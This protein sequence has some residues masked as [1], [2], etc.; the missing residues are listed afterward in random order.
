[1]PLNLIRVL[2][3]IL[4]IW[5]AVFFVADLVRAQNSLPLCQS[6]QDRSHCYAK[7]PYANGRGYF[8]GEWKGG[9]QNGFGLTRNPGGVY[10]GEF[11][12]NKFQGLG[13][14]TFANGLRFVGEFHENFSNGEGILYNPDGI[15]ISS[16]FWLQGELVRSYAIDTNRFPYAGVTREMIQ[17]ETRAQSSDRRTEDEPQVRLDR[18]IQPGASSQTNLQPT[19]HTMENLPPG[20]VCTP[21]RDNARK[22]S[23]TIPCPIEF[24]PSLKGSELTYVPSPLV[25]KTGRPLTSSV[26]SQPVSRLGDNT[27]QSNQCVPKT[28]VLDVPPPASLEDKYKAE[29]AQVR[30]RRDSCNRLIAESQLYTCRDPSSLNKTYDFYF[31]PSLVIH[32][33]GFLSGTQ[34]G[35]VR[36]AGIISWQVHPQNGLPAYERVGNR[37][38]VRSK[39]MRRNVLEFNSSTGEYFISGNNSPY[40]CNKVTRFTP[41]AQQYICQ[42]AF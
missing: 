4:S 29:Q 1:M 40:V 27:A 22:A 24:S 11:R 15:P 7:Y 16:G 37:I 41:E 5:V 14:S 10:I 30:S 25:D 23:C 17:R 26:P 12:D 39:D 36:E 13:S 6:M 8:E 20:S 34:L 19:T 28:V 2:L 32:P 35:L 18:A 3:S 9:M 42:N 38:M 31:H 33:S 21:L